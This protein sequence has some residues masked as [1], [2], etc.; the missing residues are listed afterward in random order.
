[1]EAGYKDNGVVPQ[2]RHLTRLLQEATGSQVTWM[3]KLI[4]GNNNCPQGY[5][6][7]EAVNGLAPLV[8]MGRDFLRDITFRLFLCLS[9]GGDWGQGSLVGGGINGRD[10]LLINAKSASGLVVTDVGPGAGT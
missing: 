9:H 4:V 6:G 7:L 10:A 3:C 2:G 5:L 8:Q 1:M